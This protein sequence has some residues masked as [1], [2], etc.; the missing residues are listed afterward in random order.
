M[1]MKMLRTETAMTM[2]DAMTEVS[3]I[4]LS[5][6]IATLPWVRFTPEQQDAY[7]EG[8]LA[9]M[10]EHSEWLAQ[11][12]QTPDP[13]AWMK[14]AESR[15]QEEAKRIREFFNIPPEIR[16]KREAAFWQAHI[17]EDALAPN[18]SHLTS[19]ENDWYRSMYARLAQRLFQIR[20]LL[21]VGQVEEAF[22]RLRKTTDDFWGKVPMPPG[23][24]PQDHRWA[25]VFR[26]DLPTPTPWLL[27]APT[28]SQ[29]N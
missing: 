12:R 1:T 24:D 29:E 16:L 9:E 10:R 7:I 25:D 20:L 28:P 19:D 23:L 5:I 6:P 18:D 27:C 2:M 4:K 22:L 21:V 17:N 14:R 26:Q 13:A 3:E 8:Y 11:V 15:H